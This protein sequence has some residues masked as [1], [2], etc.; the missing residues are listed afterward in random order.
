[1]RKSIYLLVLGF[2]IISIFTNCSTTRFVEP[3]EK[4]EIAI[5]ANAGGPIISLGDNVIPLPLSSVYVGYG[6][7]ENLTLYGGLHTTSLLFSNLQ[8]DLG[9]RKDLFEGYSIYP[10]ISG[11]LGINGIVGFREFKPRFFPELNVNAY[12]KYGKWRTYTGAQT[13]FDFYKN[14]KPTYGFGGF[15]VPSLVLGQDVK[16]G[17]WRIGLEYKR[18]AFNVPTENSVVNYIT[19]G[20]I[21]AQGVYLS[22]SK[23]FGYKKKKTDEKQ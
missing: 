18:L 8:F 15:F 19:F 10:S 20:G 17:D 5:G 2:G 14:F 9:A 23:S 12:W 13:W 21:G 22:C 1:M 11:A 3:L 7:K 4:D 6:Y 16:I